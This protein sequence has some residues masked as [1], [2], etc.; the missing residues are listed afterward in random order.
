MNLAA[1]VGEIER[2]LPGSGVNRDTLLGRQRFAKISF[3]GVASLRQV[4]ELEMN[5]VEQ[6]S[7]EARRD[8]RLRIRRARAFFRGRLIRRNF[9]VLHPVAGFFE[10]KPRN[11]L[12]F[13]LVEKLKIFFAKRP[14]RAPL[15]IAD[16]H[17]HHHQVHFG[18]KRGL[19]VVRGDLRLRGLLSLRESAKQE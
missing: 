17:R 16:H 13:P 19:R 3:R 2:Y 14:D 9:D 5:V 4:A 10:R 6:I 7:D 8:N 12:R 1:I 11:H 18:R 15:L